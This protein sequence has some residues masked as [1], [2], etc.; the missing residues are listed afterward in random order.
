MAAILA[1]AVGLIAS[2]TLYRRASAERDRASHQTAIAASVNRFLANDLLGRSNPFQSGRAEESLIDAVKQALPS[3]DRQFQDAPEVAARLHH[4]IARALDNRTDYADALPEYVRA[5]ALYEKT[6]GPLSED[7]IIAQ[8][9]RAAAEARSYE[10]GSLPVAKSVLAEQESRIVRITKPQEEVAVWH[11]YARGMIGLID[12]DVPAA[13]K[14]FQDA[15]DRSGKISVFDESARL[16]FKQRLAFT[17]IRLGEGVKAE[18]LFREL[19]AAFSHTDGPD[20]PNVLRVRLNLAQALMVQQKQREA[21]DE[22]TRL[23]PLYVAKLGED[24]ELSM[25]LLTTRAESEGTL[26]LYDASVRDDLKIYQLAV[27]KSGAESFF[28]IATLSDAALAQCRGKHLAEGTANA[29]RAYDASYKGFGPRA[30]LTGGAAHTLADCLIDQ[31]K[32][33]EASKLLENIDA[34]AVGQQAGSKDWFATVEFSQAEI[35]YRRGDYPSARKH[36][37]IAAPVLS[38]KDSEPYQRDALQKLTSALERH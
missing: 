35:A 18:Q 21:I 19:I 24:H 7:A 6:G 15:F 1:L 2:F 30:G 12:N 13:N 32:L 27:R 25:Q 9:Q 37:A 26:G 36:L 14:D 5:A 11:A 8:L 29:R 17:Y 3:I 33:D 22:T 10:K 38:R 23:Y 28:A 4:A 34:S 16:L 20:S 31:G